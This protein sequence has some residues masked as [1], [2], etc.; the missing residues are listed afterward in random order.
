[1]NSQSLPHRMLGKLC[2][3][4]LACCLSGAFGMGAALA[5]DSSQGRGDSGRELAQIE[6][7]VS[8]AEFEAALRLVKGELARPDNA[9]ER[10]ARLCELE[11]MLHLYLGDSD[12]ALQAFKRLLEA[13]PDYQMQEDVSPKMLALFEEARGQV[14]AHAPR[15]N[16]KLAHPR[17]RPAQPDQPIQMEIRLDMAPK[18][19]QAKLFYRRT[20]HSGFS[21]TL[22]VEH[23]EDT[24]RRIAIVPFIDLAL[25]GADAQQALP[26]GAALEYFIEV[27]DAAGALL[28][29]AGKREAPLVVPLATEA[30]RVA[31]ATTAEGDA[32]MVSGGSSAWYQKWW[33]WTIVGVVVAG[34]V[35]GGVIY[36]LSN[37]TGTVPITVT[38]E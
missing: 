2:A 3:L 36:A 32:A 15:P 14:L 7:L 18:G 24:Q 19:V 30:E 1:M 12:A 6:A 37:Q 28:A 26:N 34:A 10:L 21:S 13:S 38:V 4:C 11:G 27:Q 16:L 33:V 9:P 31:A 8:E 20:A 23:D 17:P 5:A 35:T 22:F 25:G 29:I